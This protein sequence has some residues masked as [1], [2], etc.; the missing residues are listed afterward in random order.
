MLP[1]E[2]V[3]WPVVSGVICHLWWRPPLVRGACSQFHP[4]RLRCHAPLGG[5]TGALSPSASSG[6][7]SDVVED[8]QHLAWSVMQHGSHPRSMASSPSAGPAAQSTPHSGFK[9]SRM[10]PS[11]NPML[12][13]S[14]DV[15]SATTTGVRSQGWSGEC[16]TN[17]SGGLGGFSLEDFHTLL[18]GMLDLLEAH[19]NS[20]VG[21]LVRVWSV[22][23]SALCP[24]T[25]GVIPSVTVSNPSSPVLVPLE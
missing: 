18:Q 5:V 17:S 19:R 12:Q 23:I 15:T 3:T 7:E 13:P 24:G 14:M 8:P 2:P 22:P 1:T 16:T 21:S 20:G 25:A 11:V 10:S 4:L 6:S 9:A